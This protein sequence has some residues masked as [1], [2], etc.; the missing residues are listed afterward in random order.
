M[1]KLHNVEPTGASFNSG[2][3]LLW[4]TESVSQPCLGKP[5]LL[6][7][8]AEPLNKLSVLG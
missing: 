4:P 2:D 8:S 6:P 1:Q 3:A 5:Y 7:M